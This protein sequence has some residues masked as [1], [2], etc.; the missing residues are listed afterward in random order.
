MSRNYGARLYDSLA[1]E[2]SVKGKDAATKVGRNGQSINERNELLMHRYVWYK[3]NYP[4]LI[5]FI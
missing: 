3:M 2:E 1:T 4:K 5:P